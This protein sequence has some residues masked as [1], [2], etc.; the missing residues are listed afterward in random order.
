MVCVRNWIYTLG[1]NVLKW[2]NSIDNSN[3]TFSPVAEAAPGWSLT[4]SPQSTGEK[5]KVPPSQEL[6]WY[7]HSRP[8]RVRSQ[9][10]SM[11]PTS[12][13]GI[14]LFLTIPEHSQKQLHQVSWNEQQHPSPPFHGQDENLSIWISLT[15]L[16]L[17]RKHQDI[18]S[19][20]L[21]TAWRCPN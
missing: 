11:T 8:G 15:P 4:G 20:P 16:P 13:A 3:I 12:S 1:L 21:S 14:R 10:W 19:W 2:K 5:K 9:S 17:L 18:Q 7:P 6:A